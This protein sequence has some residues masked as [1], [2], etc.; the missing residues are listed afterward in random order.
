[1]KYDGSEN[2][3][4]YQGTAGDAMYATE[5][6]LYITNF[7]SVIRL[8][9]DT[10][11]NNDDFISPICVLKHGSL[12]GPSFYKIDNQYG[13]LMNISENEY[14]QLLDKYYFTVIG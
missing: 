3:S 9:Y 4:V 13:E 11:G 6:G 12:Y 1:M 5:D 8:E 2:K 7:N 10:L 14:F